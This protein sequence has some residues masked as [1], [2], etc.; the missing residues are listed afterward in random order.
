MKVTIT[1]I[2]IHERAVPRGRMMSNGRWRS[3]DFKDWNKAPRV[4]VSTQHN[5]GNGGTVLDDL[6]Q[7]RIHSFQF[8]RKEV[9]PAVLMAMGL[10]ADTRYRW[11][12]HA[13]CSCPCSPGFIVTGDTMRR[14]V[15]VN[16]TVDDGSPPA[17]A[18]P[19][20]VETTQLVNA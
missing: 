11:S 14:D 7:R 15:F 4:Y 13:G 12:R 19:P 17:E 3:A 8:Y 20:V 16:V 10:P 5:L 18:I 9:M 6:V 1:K 2:D